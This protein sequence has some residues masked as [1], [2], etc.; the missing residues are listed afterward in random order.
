M[1]APRQHRIFGGVLVLLGCLLALVGCGGSSHSSSSSHAVPGSV[2]GRDGGFTTVIPSGFVNGLAALTGGPITL[3]YV[4]VGPKVGGF[5]TN[6][7]VVREPAHGLSDPDV[8]V[9]RELVGLKTAAPQAHAF[10]AIRKLT[11]DRAPARGVDYLNRPANGPQLHQYQV[12]AVHGDLIYTVTYT[13]LQAR[14]AAS[15]PAMQQ[16]LAGWRWK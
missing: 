10:S 12:F 3:Q 8:V 6:V 16:V 5:R 2:T 4:A 14:Y 15:L 7:N 13:A 11:L 1:H 9:R